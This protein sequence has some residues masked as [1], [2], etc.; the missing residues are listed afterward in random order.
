MIERESPVIC[1]IGAE[2]IFTKH[3]IKLRK[4]Y[5]VLLL[6]EAAVFL[7]QRSGTDV[8]RHA[9]VSNHEIRT[10]RNSSFPLLYPMIPANGIEPP[11]ELTRIILH[12]L[13]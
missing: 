11:V 6:D 7:Q 2:T 13:F 5:A 3:L 4:Q 1:P 10:T 8:N 12:H 9:L